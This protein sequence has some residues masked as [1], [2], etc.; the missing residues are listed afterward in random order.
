MQLGFVEVR[1]LAMYDLSVSTL[2]LLKAEFDGGHVSTEEF[3]KGLEGII[4]NLE[5]SI[6]CLEVEETGT[7]RKLIA[8]RATHILHQIKELLLFSDCI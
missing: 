6:K 7:Y 8:D 4:E 5:T 3:K 2:V 1:G